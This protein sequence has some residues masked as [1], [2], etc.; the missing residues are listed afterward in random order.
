MRGEFG[1]FI[2][3]KSEKTPRKT[4]QAK[5]FSKFNYAFNISVPKKILTEIL[6]INSGLKRDIVYD[7]FFWLKGF[8][9]TA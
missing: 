3:G 9:I 4:W 7:F 5:N 1:R 6:Y 8:S 2:N